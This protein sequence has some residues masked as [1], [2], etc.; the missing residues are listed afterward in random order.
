MK[1]LFFASA[2]LVAF[3]AAGQAADL[4]VPRA[5]VAAAV[6][7]P[8]FNW[9]G[10]Y[11]GAH[12]G[13]G[14]G[15]TGGQFFFNAGPTFA[16]N[17]PSSPSGAFGGLQLGYNWQVN[18]FVVGAETDLSAAG[19]RDARLY[20]VN[21]VYTHTT[22]VRWVGSTRLRLGVAADKALFYVTGGLAYGGVTV[23]TTPQPVGL[24]SSRTRVGYALGAGLEY[25]FTPNLTAKVEYM[26]YNLGS[27]NY[28]QSPVEYMRSNPQIHTV[29]LGLNYLFSTGPS[30]VVARY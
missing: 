8:V 27:A 20:N 3:T 10:F 5:P 25:A 28:Q 18:N 21:P 16:S 11:L 13:Y 12:V 17:E 15:R 9:T 19:F 29:K 30:A 26:Y 4:G 24:T 2:A 22:S 7:A 6:V 1:N 23:S 14:W